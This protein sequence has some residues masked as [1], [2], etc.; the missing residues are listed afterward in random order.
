M[1]AISFYTYIVGSFMGTVPL[2]LK[3]NRIKKHGT[4]EELDAHVDKTVSNWSRNVLN[5]I[6]AKVLI[7]GNDNLPEGSCLFVSNHQGNFDFL[8][9][10]GYINKPIGFVAKTEIGKFPYYPEW[11]KAMHCVFIDRN[12]PRQS[13]KAIN[14]AADNLKNGYSM[15]I[16]PEGTRSKGHNMGE[17]KKGSLKLALKAGVPIVPV[18]LDGSYKIYEGNNGKNFKAE[19]IKIIIDKP[20]YVDELSKEEQKDLT[21]YVQ[22]IIQ[23]NLDTI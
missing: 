3:M 22:A 7:K 18:T 16:Y 14:E 17:F 10:M 21:G 12:N 4:K 9:M 11:M 2:K 15:V 23:K 8:A 1:K 5:K 19:E 20:I 6:G 13:V